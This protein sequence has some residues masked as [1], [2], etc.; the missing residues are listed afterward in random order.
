MS[1]DAKDVMAG[2][3]SYLTLILIITICL[4][5]N[6][7]PYMDILSGIVGAIIGAIIAAIAMYLVTK[8]SDKNKLTVEIIT[9]FLKKTENI[10]KVYGYLEKPS[11]FR[12]A[13][14]DDTQM[15]IVKSTRM[16]EILEL[17]NSLNTISVL[18]RKG[19]LNPEIIDETSF[20][21][22]CAKFVKIAKESG[23]MEGRDRFAKFL[24]ETQNE[25]G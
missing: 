4:T 16:N 10:G 8:S 12:E 1:K 22:T 20:N 7:E 6:K 17:G 11:S 18:Y 15:K 23:I 21:S 5:E 9:E 19:Y 14:G 13:S 24:F 3:L 2:G 25:N